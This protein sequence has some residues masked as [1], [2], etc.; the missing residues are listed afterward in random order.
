LKLSLFFDVTITLPDHLPGVRNMSES[1][2]MAE[3]AVSLYAGK[4]LTLVQGADLAGV[5]LFAFQRALQAHGIPQH[6]DEAALEDDLANLDAM[7]K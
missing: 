5:D 4:K 3:L 1:E 6:Y 7:T 2:I